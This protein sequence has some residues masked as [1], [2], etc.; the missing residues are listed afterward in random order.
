MD[1]IKRIEENK[2][3]YTIDMPLKNNSKYF[4]HSKEE[5]LKMIT[6]DCRK[7]AER[8][9]NKPAPDD[10]PIEFEVPAETYKRITI[11]LE[12]PLMRSNNYRSI[13]LFVPDKEKERYKGMD[14]KIE[15]YIGINWIK[16]ELLLQ[17]FNENKNRRNYLASKKFLTTDYRLMMAVVREWKAA[18][19][20]NCF[21]LFDVGEF[22]WKL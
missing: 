12:E 2:K 4:I 8:T 1:E 10:K 5:I 18:M 6:E 11:K 17:S 22:I 13:K 7:L 15:K 21:R 9:L 3:I 20:N 16:L 14:E 19:K